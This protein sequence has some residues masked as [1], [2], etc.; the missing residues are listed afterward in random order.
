MLLVCVV[1]PSK[2][3]NSWPSPTQFAVSIQLSSPAGRRSPSNLAS[4]ATPWIFMHLPC[5]VAG[6]AG[7]H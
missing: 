2:S 7:L 3:L 4:Q 5:D 1:M 6:P